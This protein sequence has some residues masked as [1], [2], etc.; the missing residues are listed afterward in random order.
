MDYL[1]LKKIIS[2]YHL[3]LDWVHWVHYVLRVKNILQQCREI[4]FLESKCFFHRL[5]F[6]FKLVF[7]SALHQERHFLEH[8]KGMNEGSEVISISQSLSAQCPTF[9]PCSYRCSFTM[10][11]IYTAQP[12]ANQDKTQS[13]LSINHYCWCPLSFYTVQHNVFPSCCF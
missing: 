3:L 10:C 1:T 4:W 2:E 12:P 9:P 13:A 6:D 5:V 8:E 11:S 7:L